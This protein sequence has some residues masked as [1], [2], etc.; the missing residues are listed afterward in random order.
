MDATGWTVDQVDEL[1]IEDLGDLL[2]HWR[3]AP[4]LVECVRGLLQIKPAREEPKTES[5][6]PSSV[7]FDQMRAAMKAEELQFGRSG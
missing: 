4:P 6:A 1:D 3:A 7:T 2:D 5:G